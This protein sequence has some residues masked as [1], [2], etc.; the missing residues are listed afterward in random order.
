[1]TKDK[2]NNFDVLIVVNFTS[3]LIIKD[4]KYSESYECSKVYISLYALYISQ[5]SYYE[6]IECS[7]SSDKKSI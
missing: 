7:E 1:M 3:T 2:S 4:I 6:S 5:S